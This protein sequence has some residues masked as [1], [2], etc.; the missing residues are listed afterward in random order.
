MKNIILKI[1]H[2]QLEILKKELVSLR[3]Y[4]LEFDRKCYEIEICE[5][6]QTLNAHILG[7]R[8]PNLMQIF[9]EMSN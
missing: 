7:L 2:C 3:C 5:F 6:H 1:E 9:P 4:C 8:D